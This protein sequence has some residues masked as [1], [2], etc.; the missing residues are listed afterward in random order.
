M[1]SNIA[2]LQKTDIRG[3]NR[4]SEITSCS[5]EILLTRN[6][7]NGALFPVPKLPLL[8]NRHTNGH[9]IRIPRHPG[10]WSS[11]HHFQS[12]FNFLPTTTHRKFWS[13]TSLNTH[14]TKLVLVSMCYRLLIEQFYGEYPRFQRVDPA[15]RASKN[16]RR[17]THIFASKRMIIHL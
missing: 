4:F 12:P 9:L 6:R 11:W 7:L 14:A 17:Y 2:I 5:R 1:R 10:I 8:E 15:H 3:L 16:G 13:R